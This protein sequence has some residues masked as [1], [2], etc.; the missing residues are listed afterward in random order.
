MV[1]CLGRVSLLQSV[2]NSL[3]RV[4]ISLSQCVINSF[5][6]KHNTLSQFVG[7]IWVV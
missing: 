6:R 1:N 3:S 4:R 7:Y 2:V 5:G